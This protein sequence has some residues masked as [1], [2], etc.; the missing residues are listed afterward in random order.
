MPQL[1]DLA[2]SDL[3]RGIAIGLGAAVLIPIAAVV[4]APYLKPA[5]RTALKFGILGLEKAR[6]A[7]A[8]LAETLEDMN[9]EVQDELRAAR[10][11]RH[12]APEPAEPTISPRDGS[13]RDTAA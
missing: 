2:K 7:A 10:A 6:E 9:A 4:L 12:A 5:A 8:S 1:E 13:P 3:T 11:A